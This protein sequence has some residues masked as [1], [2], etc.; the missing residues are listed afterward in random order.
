M[1]GRAS[2]GLWSFSRS[3][4][5]ALSASP[6]CCQNRENVAVPFTSKCLC[7]DV[8]TRIAFVRVRAMSVRFADV[9]VE[10]GGEG[11]VGRF[12][13][14]ESDCL[15][16][17]TCSKIYQELNISSCLLL[18]CGAPVCAATRHRICC[19]MFFS[20]VNLATPL[21]LCDIRT[22][23]VSSPAAMSFPPPFPSPARLPL[24]QITQPI[25]LTSG[26]F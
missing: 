3:C 12:S 20:K 6:R 14:Y 10:D 22:R 4:S 19:S 11:S 13:A 5:T 15:Q 21:A 17:S 26:V 7:C 1:S 23:G 2:S 18:C 25:E 16:S 8:T 9:L 24:Q